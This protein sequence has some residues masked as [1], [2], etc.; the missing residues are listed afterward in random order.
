MQPNGFGVEVEHLDGRVTIRP[1][2]E[3]DLATAPMLERALD[4]VIDAGQ[5]V[6]LDLCGVTFADCA[7]LEPVRWA[8]HRWPSGRIRIV[9]ARRPVERVLTLTGMQEPLHAEG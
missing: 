5:A 6:V 4:D 7:G 1:S 2:G 8:L 9:G 3:L